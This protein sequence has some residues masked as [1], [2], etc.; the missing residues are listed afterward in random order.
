MICFRN[1]HPDISDSS[2]HTDTEITWITALCL[3]HLPLW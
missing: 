2:R 3:V 1:K